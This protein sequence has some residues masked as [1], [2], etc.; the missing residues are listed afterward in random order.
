MW[1][2]KFTSNRCFCK[3]IDFAY[4]EIYEQ[5]FSN[6]HLRLRKY[7][8]FLP[9]RSMHC[10]LLHFCFYL[11]GPSINRKSSDIRCA[12]DG[13]KIVDHS[14]AVG[15]SPV[16]AAP[17]SSSF[18]TKHLT[19]K[20]LVITIARPHEKHLSFVILCVTYIRDFT[21]YFDIRALSVS[22]SV[23]LAIGVLAIF[24]HPEQYRQQHLL[25]Q[26]LLPVDG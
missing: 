17:T 25:I 16:G 6:P 18:S 5:I 9:H 1:L 14:D 4:W 8:I 13:N 26:F 10:S 15:A 22:H 7:P 23:G 11:V 20:D 2:K 19:S 3:I 21:V 24:N 12:S